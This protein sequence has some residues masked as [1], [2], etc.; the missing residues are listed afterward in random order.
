M[1][2]LDYD[3][4]VAKYNAGGGIPGP[5][6]ETLGSVQAAAEAAG[7]TAAVEVGAGNCLLAAELAASGVNVV[8]VDISNVARAEGIHDYRHMDA[9]SDEFF[10]LLGPDVLLYGRRSLCLMYN[11]DWLARVAATGC[12][13]LFSEALDDEPHRFPNAATEV[14]FLRD[15]GW[16]STASGRFVTARLADAAPQD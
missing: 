6:A 16:S 15:H 10:A 11:P 4:F 8:A 14:K 7:L 3:G 9:T 5:V 13:Y 1:P 2:L 12:H